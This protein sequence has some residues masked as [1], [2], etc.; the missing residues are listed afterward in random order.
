[1]TLR[2]AGIGGVAALAALALVRLVLAQLGDRWAALRESDDVEAL[3]GDVPGRMV[4]VDGHRVHLVERGEGPAVL[5][6]HGTGGTTFDW[7]SSVLDSLAPG[8]RVIA[9]DLYGMGFSERNEAFHYGF[10]LWADQLVG[11]L[12]ALGIERA[13]VIGQ[14]L[15]GAIATAFAGRHPERVERLVSV[16]SGPWLPPFM[17]VLLTPGLGE[18]FLGRRDYWPERPDEPPAYA[19]RMRQVYRIRGTRRA[20]LRAIR[21]QF[22]DART[23]FSALA[24]VACPVLLVHGGADDI[25]PLRAAASLQRRLPGSQLV[26]LEGAGHFAMQDAPKQFAEVVERFL[27]GERAAASA[28]RP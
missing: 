2:G 18:A 7:E 4:Q 16:D 22:L 5:L 26:V 27:H 12:D 20:L 24:R 9:L 17:G 13:S 3:P 6:V 8:H 15:G 19:E 10:A 28:G 25:I 1:M 14:S 21:G 23:Y 11:T